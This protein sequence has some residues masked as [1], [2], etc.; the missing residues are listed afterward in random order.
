[1]KVIGLTGN[2]GCGKSV[3]AKMFEELGAKVIDADQIARMIVQP[4]EPAWKE[5]V[6]KF[7]K[8]ILKDDGTIDRQKLGK[9]VFEDEGKREELNQITHPRIIGK[10]REL[11]EKYRRE[12]QKVVIVEAALIVEKGGLRDIIDEL[13]VVTSDE[14]TQIKRLVEGRGLSKEEAISRIKSQMP[15]EEKVKHATYVIDNSGS[16]EETRKQV[17]RI[18]KNIGLESF[19]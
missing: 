1:M 11:I 5:I 13:I 19:D 8:G 7:G 16:L 10:I 6:E 3:V 18:W 9:I 17:E 2:I 15:V 14:E 12:N 4:G